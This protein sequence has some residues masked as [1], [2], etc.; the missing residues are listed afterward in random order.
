MKLFA[1]KQGSESAKALAEALEIKR[2]RKTGKDI[3]VDVLLNWGC[4]KLPNRI[5]YEDVINAPA[6]IHMAANKLE[7]FLAL[8]GEV[9]IPSFTESRDGGMYSLLHREP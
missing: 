7:T 9:C 4:S 2:I 6:N 5:V 1:Y 8:E 3:R